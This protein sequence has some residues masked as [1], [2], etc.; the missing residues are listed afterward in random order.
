MTNYQELSEEMP[1]GG[2]IEGGPHPYDLW[3]KRQGVRVY[4]G[5]AVDDLKTLELSPWES[6]GGRGAVIRF[7]GSGYINDGQVV[8][9]DPSQKLKPQRQL[10]EEVVFIVSGRGATQL[11]YNE[12]EKQIIEWQRH[13][14]FAIP[15]NVTFQHFNTDPKYPARY[16]S[17]TTAPIVFD[18]FGNEDFIFN[19]EYKFLDRFSGPRSDYQSEVKTWTRNEFPPQV[20]ESNFVPD[21]SAF[22]KLGLFEGRGIGNRGV[23]FKLANGRARVHMSEFPEGTYKKAHRHG[24]AANVIITAGK[25][26]SLMWQGD[27][28]QPDLLKRAV[29]IDWHEDSVFVPPEMWWHQHFN[30]YNGVSRYM[31]IHPTGTMTDREEMGTQKPGHEAGRNQIEYSEEDSEVCRLFASELKKSG[32]H[33]DHRMPCASK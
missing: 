17:S 8:E 27:K 19:S 26:Y 25:G 5:Y 3:L 14:L 28:G 12:N 1:K 9:F 18:L 33:L 24:P 10:F 22:D 6:K 7:F 13:S 15:P 21:V 29:R 20:W 4:R 32:A 31:P 30:T 16:Y 23:L 11:W 2:P